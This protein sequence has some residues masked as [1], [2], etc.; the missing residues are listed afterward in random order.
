MPYDM[1]DDGT[2]LQDALEFVHQEDP[3]ECCVYH[4]ASVFGPTKDHVTTA[5]EN[6][7]GTEKV[8]KCVAQYPN[9]RLVLTSSMAAVRG[10]GQTPLNGKVYTY[11][12]WNT[13]S[14]LGDNWGASYQWSKAE[15]ERRA[16]ELSK[17][18]G[19]AHGIVVSIVCVWTSVG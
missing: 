5:H 7:E 8:V 3:C 6:V 14:K 10:T 1:L 19:R 2:T 15:S 13:S 12:D 18:L 11:K 4:V 9:C 16:W 17:E